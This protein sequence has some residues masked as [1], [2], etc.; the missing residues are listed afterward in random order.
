MGD[1]SWEDLTVPVNCQRQEGLHFPRDVQSMDGERKDRE[2]LAE[3]SLY[4]RYSDTQPS[5]SQPVGSS[6]NLMYM[7][8]KGPLFKNPRIQTL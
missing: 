4:Q 6:S 7:V 3:M 8:S 1:S 2:D 5:E